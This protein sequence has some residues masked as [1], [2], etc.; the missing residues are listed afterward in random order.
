MIE[1]LK[2]VVVILVFF[3]MIIGICYGSWWI[4]RTFNWNF[5]Y[6][7]QFDRIEKKVNDLNRR[8][9]ILELKLGRKK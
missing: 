4:R 8:V 6:G 5:Y 1:K 3:G 2:V 9:T 7:K